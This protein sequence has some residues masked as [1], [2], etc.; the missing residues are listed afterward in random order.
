MP[1]PHCEATSAFD[2]STINI[3]PPQAHTRGKLNK[4]LRLTGMTDL[5]VSGDCM[6]FTVANHADLAPQLEDL[7]TEPEQRDTRILVTH[8]EPITAAHVASVLTAEAY[9]VCVKGAWLEDVLKERRLNFA[10]QPIL[11]GDRRVYGHEA[12]VRAQHRDGSPISPAELFQAAGT[13]ALL[14]TLDREARLTAVSNV[15]AM[16]PETY[17][18]INFMP[19]TIYD[20]VYCLQSTDKTAREHG[21]DP[22]Q[23]IFEVVE[24]DKIQDAQH[25]KRIIEFYRHSGYRV[26]LDDF[27][28]GHNNLH[29]M[30]EYT[31]DF[32]K[33]DKAITQRLA[34]D[35]ISRGMVRDLIRQSE[36][37][38]TQVIIEGIETETD[39]TVCRDLGA[40]FYQGF[41]FAKPAPAFRTEV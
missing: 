18:F 19:S 1:C 21:I 24:S 17:M 10:F 3:F 28:T 41:Y 36:A 23:I 32:V 4:A 11:N 2:G 33:V 7:L 26:A 39:F 12:L 13:P 29:A 37:Q 6:T 8:G 25:L 30:L 34:E 9:I 31:P 20:P 15:P 27:G 16:P 35:S 38:K 22:S 40:H 5:T 14:A